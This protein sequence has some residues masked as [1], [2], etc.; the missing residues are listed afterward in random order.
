[1]QC[2]SVNNSP[3]IIDIKNN[4]SFRKNVRIENFNKNSIYSNLYRNNE[5]L[6]EKN[7]SSLL[8]LNKLLF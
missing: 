6:I 1:M 8:F 5:I 4:P 3:K 7:L 2:C